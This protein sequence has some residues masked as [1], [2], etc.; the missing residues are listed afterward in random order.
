MTHLLALNTSIWPI[1]SAF[2]F[3]LLNVNSQGSIQG[4]RQKVL[5]EYIQL[6][7]FYIES[8]QHAKLQWVVY[9]PLLLYLQWRILPKFLKDSMKKVALLKL[10]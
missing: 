10:K 7:F 6:G 1:Q 9:G 4:S 2:C 3:T 5:Y 8:L